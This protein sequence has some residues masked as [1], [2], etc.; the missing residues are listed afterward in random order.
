MQLSEVKDRWLAR[1]TQA[2]E[3]DKQGLL[4]DACDTLFDTTAWRGKQLGESFPFAESTFP[5]WGEWEREAWVYRGLE[6]VLSDYK[7]FVDVYLDRHPA[8]D[9]H[10]VIYILD[11]S[12]IYKELQVIQ[13]ERNLM[14]M[15]SQ[16]RSN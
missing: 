5:Y 16:K 3:V 8:K 4:V 11:Q 6:L 12:E 10:R 15:R 9:D 1:R 13:N 14:N 2:L 7:G